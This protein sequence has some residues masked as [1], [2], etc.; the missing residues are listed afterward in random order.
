MNRPA[1]RELI[2]HSTYLIVLLVATS[3]ITFFVMSRL[4]M[5]CDW[6]SVALAT[7]SVA[8]AVVPPLWIETVLGPMVAA[9]IAGVLWRLG[10]L[11][12]VVVLST[13]KL[14]AARNCVQVT[15]LVCY[16]VTLPLESWL[17]IRQTRQ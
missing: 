4:R 15:L 9:P 16:F 7:L 6:Q 14:E 13:Y 11:L 10:V 8:V 12:P 2:L 3:A 17:L 5:S 1:V